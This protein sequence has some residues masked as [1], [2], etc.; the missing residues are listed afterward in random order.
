MTVKGGLYY[1][2]DYLRI[3][4][5]CRRIP[6]GIRPTWIRLEDHMV[7]TVGTRCKDTMGTQLLCAALWR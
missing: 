3:I 7:L 5:R 1:A 2:K 4:R 6:I